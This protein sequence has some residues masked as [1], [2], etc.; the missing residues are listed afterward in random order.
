MRGFAFCLLATKESTLFKNSFRG[1]KLFM[2]KTTRLILIISGLI[3]VWGALNSPSDLQLLIYTFFVIALLLRSRIAALVKRIALNP[4]VKFIFLIIISGWIAET[5][6]WATHYIAK[7]EV[8]LLLH[9]QLIP[10]L[11]LATGFY[12]GWAL[13]WVITLRYFQFSLA[14]VFVTAGLPA[15]FIEGG[16]FTNFLE[17]L[18]ANPL[19]SV[20]MVVYIFVVYG[21]IMGLAYL[22]IENE[23]RNP[24][25][26][27]SWFKYP[28]V[29][30]LIFLAPGVLMAIVGFL[31][32][33]LGLIPERGPIWERPF[34]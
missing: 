4:F 29:W 25:Q 32:T 12:G 6:A 1:R 31:A 24:R 26:R 23:L 14:S 30:T 27:N 11:I 20:L 10:D 28:I 3:P 16:A 17:G 2:K 19:G 34:F 7:S 5:L 15:L 9:S 8:P 22:S 18:A 21:S 13:A 33:P